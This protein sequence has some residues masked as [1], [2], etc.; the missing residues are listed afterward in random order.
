MD[1]IPNSNKR[2]KSSYVSRSSG[3]R[4]NYTELSDKCDEEDV[5]DSILRWLL[6]NFRTSKD[7]KS[8]NGSKFHKI[9]DTDGRIVRI[10]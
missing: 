10:R 4:V 5:E 3:Q 2:S 9:A 8:N 6:H 1:I 7:N